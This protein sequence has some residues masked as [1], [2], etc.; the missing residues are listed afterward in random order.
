MAAPTA[1]ELAPA[2]SDWDLIVPGVP[3]R[4]SAVSSDSETAPDVVV[5]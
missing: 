1:I 4:T 5:E 3:T 2:A